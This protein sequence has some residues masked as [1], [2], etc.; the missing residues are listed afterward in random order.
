MLKNT[1]FFAKHH[2][3]YAI[4]QKEDGTWEVK[5]RRYTLLGG[6]LRLGVLNR[7]PAD[8]TPDWAVRGSLAEGVFVLF[9]DSCPPWRGPEHMANYLAR[10]GM[11]GMERIG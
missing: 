6:P 8:V 4:Q 3:P 10:L 1:E 11:L 5:S 2:L 7:L 9:S